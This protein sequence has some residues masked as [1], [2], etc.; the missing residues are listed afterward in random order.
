[1]FCFLPSGIVVSTSS[2][3]CDMT[4]ST[5]LNDIGKSGFDDMDMRIYLGVDQMSM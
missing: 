2:K 5:A 3:R 4:R 1:M